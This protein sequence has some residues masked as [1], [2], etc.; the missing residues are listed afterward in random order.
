ML[1]PDFSDMLSALSEE[2]AEFLLVGAYALA[3]HGV[4][5]ATGD[6]DILVRPTPANAERIWKALIRFGAPLA[7]LSVDDFTVL[8]RV[9]QIGVEPC[10]IDLLTAITGVTFDEAWG[11]RVVVEVSGLRI[12]VLSRAHLV[13]NKRQTGRPQDRADVTR[14]ED[15]AKD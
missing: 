13:Q 15:K 5:R 7:D 10:R 9:V 14:L 4:P 6:M 11:D 12:P 3:A 1:N 2:G 8:G